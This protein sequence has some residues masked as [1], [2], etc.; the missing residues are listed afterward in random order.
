MTQQLHAD[1]NHVLG[2]VEPSHHVGVGHVGLSGSW[3]PHGD[4][5]GLGLIAL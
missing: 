4:D 3:C 1:P 5:P 2:R